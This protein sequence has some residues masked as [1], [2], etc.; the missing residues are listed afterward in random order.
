MR[1]I[2]DAI[3][4][5]IWIKILTLIS[6]SLIIAS[7]LLPQMGLIDSSTLA[8]VG[9]LFAWAALWALIHALDNG[10]DAKLTK[11][12]VEINIGDNN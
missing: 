7:F 1:K 2:M 4:N 10:K 5:N 3:H 11:G 8:A 9:E 6:V 12:D